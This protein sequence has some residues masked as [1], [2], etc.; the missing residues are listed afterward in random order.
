MYTTVFSYGKSMPWGTVFKGWE[1][2][3]VRDRVVLKEC[4]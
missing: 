3:R 2:V 1:A 4:K